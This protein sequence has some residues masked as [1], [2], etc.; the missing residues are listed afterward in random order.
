MN[1]N[2]FVFKLEDLEKKLKE[3]RE[4]SPEAQYIELSLHQS[5]TLKITGGDDIN[6]PA[7]LLFD[8]PDG[9]GGST[10][11]E[12]IEGVSSEKFDYEF[13]VFF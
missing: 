12:E 7:M 3:I 8:V 13:N 2:S 10:D 5:E 6:I 4:V 1:E 9:W 11:F